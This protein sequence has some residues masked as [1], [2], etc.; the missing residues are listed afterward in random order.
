[1]IKYP[2]C[3]FADAGADSRH[4]WFCAADTYNTIVMVTS[5]QISK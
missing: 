1:M 5:I 2:V 4:V 3:E